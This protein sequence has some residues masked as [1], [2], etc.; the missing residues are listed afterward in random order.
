MF[1]GK[2][3]IT[4]LVSL[5][6]ALL[7]WGACGG[8][9][10]STPVPPVETPIAI[11]SLDGETDVSLTS[12]FKYTFSEA[13]ESSTVTS[14]TFFIYPASGTTASKIAATISAD[15]TTEY[16]ITPDESLTADTIYVLMVRLTQITSSG[17]ANIADVKAAGDAMGIVDEMVIFT[18]GSD[19]IP[20]FVGVLDTTFVSPTGYLTGASMGS[21]NGPSFYLALD[22]DENIY[23]MQG[24][25]DD[26]PNGFS[27]KKFDSLGN[28]D[29]TFATSGT[30]SDVTGNNTGKQLLIN[31][32][33]IFIVASNY[34][35]DELAIF[36]YDT[37]GSLIASTTYSD[38]PFI[39]A[40]NAAMDSDG[41]VLITGRVGPD[42]TYDMTIWRYT[43]DLSI[44]TSFGINGVVTYNDSGN[45]SMG[46][47]IAI[48][49]SNNIYVAGSESDDDFAT[50]SVRIWKYDSSGIAV[51]SFG[52]NGI[53][54][55]GAHDYWGNVYV[56][57]SDNIFVTITDDMMGSTPT[58]QITKCDSDGN[59]DTS[60][61]SSGIF[62]YEDDNVW[63]G[64]MATDDD[65]NLL[66]PASVFTSTTT[67]D[68]V[69]WVLTSDTGELVT[70]SGNDGTFQFDVFETPILG[71]I[72]IDSRGRAL[73][74]GVD[75]EGVW[76]NT[77]S[78]FF[79]MKVR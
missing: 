49:S 43:S 53:L 24:H 65:G 2:R 50:S 68:L 72:V 67:T 27:A 66:I 41:K 33:S 71:N 51:A 35:S 31:N 6:A 12:A 55:L 64:R 29:T 58:S 79:I 13:V 11:E 60:F 7:F 1:M 38:T 28:I 74:C 18:T 52:T 70:A 20:P 14:D 69:I 78:P 42:F 46:S 19:A 57:P 30:L 23:Y 4:F 59:I 63:P 75:A 22:S 21:T 48:D 40:F 47:S 16:I 54:D 62:N 17:A 56:D 61:G 76:G 8:T 34:N 3:M 15:S 5:T 37:N 10:S 36:K 9:S 73:M 44:D 25:D 26:D 77:G 32:D 45:G 39:D